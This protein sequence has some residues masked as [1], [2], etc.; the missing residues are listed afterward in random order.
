MFHIDVEYLEYKIKSAGTTKEAVAAECGIHRTTL[1]RNLRKN[2]ISLS[3]V[4]AIIAF[5][6]LSPD[7]I[8]RTFFAVCDA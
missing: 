7:D 2:S 4:Y 6:H 1:W 5:L 8:E 3:V